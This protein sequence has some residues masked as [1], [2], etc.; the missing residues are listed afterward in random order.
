MINNKLTKKYYV[1]SEVIRIL[2]IA[3]HKLRYLETK[4]PGLSHYKINN[5][6]Y[7]TAHDIDLLQKFLFVS[8]REEYLEVRGYHRSDKDYLA[9]FSNIHCASDTSRQNEF[10]G[11]N[12]ECILNLHVQQ[13]QDSQSAVV[14][15]LMDNTVSSRIDILLT[16]F[17][18]LSIQIKKILLIS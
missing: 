6:K 13:R 1:A 5:R 16:N 17:H 12:S 7:Y 18:N 8:R 11:K 9:N 2:N 4:I 15:S 10:Q 3:L 14:L